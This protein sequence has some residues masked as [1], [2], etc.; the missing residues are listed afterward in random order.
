ML[1]IKEYLHPVMLIARSS[2]EGDE[3]LWCKLTPGSSRDLIV[4]CIYRRPGSV[5]SQILTDLE[6]FG[7][8]GKV[9]VLG[10]FNS[11]SIDWSAFE[12]TSGRSVFEGQLMDKAMNVP[13]HQH[14]RFDTWE[15]RPGQSSLL[16]LVF[17]RFED[18]VNSMISKE[19][20]GSSDHVVIIFDYCY[21][22]RETAVTSLRRNFHKADYTAMREKA[23]AL[24]WS[25]EN[26]TSVNEDWVRFMQKIE[27][28]IDGSVPFTRKKQK[29]NSAPWISRDIRK[30]MKKRQR[31]WKI[32]RETGLPEHR[33][34]YKNIQKYLQNQ[35]E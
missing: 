6:F 34:E 3:S 19:P 26:L 14:V 27:C 28:V 15:G 22:P 24:D 16:D 18:E 32:Y 31:K 30:S 21:D 11:P 4:G 25:T 12:T 1:Y 9:I 29:R 13:L 8:A 35:C 10:D 23:K 17:T 20:L 2:L 5:G 33:E 7:K